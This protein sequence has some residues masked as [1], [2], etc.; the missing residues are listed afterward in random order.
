SAYREIRVSLD[1][2]TLDN[3]VEIKSTSTV[4]VPPSGAVV[5]VNFETDEARS[6]ILQLL[7]RD[8]GFIPLGAHVLNEKNQTVGT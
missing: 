3:D 5:L 4:T 8:K 1:I 6:L 2:S 7:R